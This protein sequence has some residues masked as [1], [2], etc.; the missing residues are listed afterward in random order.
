MM[1][2]M[3]VISAAGRD[4]GRLLAVVRADAEGVWVADGKERPLER[5][6]RK[7]PKHIVQTEYFLKQPFPSTNRRLRGALRGLEASLP[8]S[9]QGLEVSELV[10]R[11][12]N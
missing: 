4:R 3:I 2:G 8:T 9:I 6:K 7:N 12:C 10:E 5:P 11:R 1:Q